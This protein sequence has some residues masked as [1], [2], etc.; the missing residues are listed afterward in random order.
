MAEP[1]VE[2]FSPMYMAKKTGDSST[3]PKAAPN[4]SIAL[5]M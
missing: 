4:K 5:F 3:N 1:L 2:S